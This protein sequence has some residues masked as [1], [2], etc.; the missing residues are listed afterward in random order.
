M[1][2]IEKPKLQTPLTGH[3]LESLTPPICEDGD[4]VI[5]EVSVE[6]HLFLNQ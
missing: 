6:Q 1:N 3:S 2:E 4:G 5:L